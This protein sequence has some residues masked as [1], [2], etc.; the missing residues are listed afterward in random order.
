MRKKRF[1]LIRIK[2]TDGQ[3]KRYSKNC[4]VLHVSHKHELHKLTMTR[5]S[6]QA[7]ELF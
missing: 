1:E 3:K 4:H 7:S 6:S 2:Y 5:I